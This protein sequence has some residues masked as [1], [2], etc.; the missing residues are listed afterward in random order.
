MSQGNKDA[1]E[2]SELDL[3]GIETVPANVFLWGGYRYSN[4]RDAVAAAKR[5]AKP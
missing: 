4:A 3:Y 2:Q 1:V 5:S